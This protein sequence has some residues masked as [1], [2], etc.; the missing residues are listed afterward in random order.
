MSSTARLQAQGVY[1]Q[2]WAHRQRHAGRTAVVVGEAPNGVSVDRD[3]LLVDTAATPNTAAAVLA[4][5]AAC[6][7]VTLT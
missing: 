2:Q 6:E 7:Q 5:T 1:W 4:N 3:I